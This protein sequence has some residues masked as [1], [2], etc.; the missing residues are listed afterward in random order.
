MNFAATT[1]G[2]QG[3]AAAAAESKQTL[4]SIRVV[5]E[6]RKSEKRKRKMSKLLLIT[7]S[8]FLNNVGDYGGM[9]IKNLEVKACKSRKAVMQE[10]AAADEGVVVIAS[11]DMMAAD[12]ARSKEAGQGA[13]A[14]V[15]FYFNQIFYKMT[16]RVD[17]S[18]GKI[19]FG[20]VA[21]LF[22]TAHSEAV[23]RAMFH[24]FKVMKATPVNNI[25]C[26]ELMKDV[27]AGSDGTHLTQLSANRYI[28]HVNNFFIK[29]C[30]ESGLAQVELSGPEAQSQ[31]RSGDWSEEMEVGMEPEVDSEAVNSLEPPQEDELA[32]ARAITML[33]PSMLTQM[34]PTPSLAGTASGSPAHTMRNTPLNLSRNNRAPGQNRAPDATQARL[35]NLASQT[36]DTS[37]PPPALGQGRSNGPGLGPGTLTL[38]KRVSQLESNSFYTNLMTA[39]LKEEQDTEANK[40]LLNRVTVSGVVIE[41]LTRMNDTDKVRAMR[42]KIEELFNQIKEPEQTL[43]VQFVRHLNKQVRGQKSAVIEVKLADA[44]QAKLLRAEFVKKFN[45]FGKK[46]NITPVVRLATRVRIEIMHSV[47]FY[48]KR[49]DPTITKAACLQF[50]PKPVIK[51]TRK[52]AGGT[53]TSRTMTFAD[54]IN[55]VKENGL[56]DSIDL[57]KAR[58][59]AGASF[60]GTLQQHFVLLD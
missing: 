18:D 32:P 5:I 35:I 50:V 17:E 59:R 12:I 24:S 6:V 16:E 25:W 27:K 8:N 38:E 15:E 41:N 3:S 57:S 52:T 10:L 55:W 4:S 34:R 36:P 43:E 22:W 7:D 1:L 9:K 53:E 37:R 47:C 11:L 58:D 40:A 45:V 56:M 48:L 42:D 39:I 14:A 44:Q 54:S 33:S 49:N 26:S 28:E 20:V 51:V 31:P 30:T 19:A 23:K 21:P 13:D 29:V 60:R 2:K 46:I